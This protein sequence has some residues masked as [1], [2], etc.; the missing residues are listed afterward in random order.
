MQ[1]FLPALVLLV[2]SSV[3]GGQDPT[4]APSS[5]SVDALW[6]VIIV[7]SLL[8]CCSLGGVVFA[9]CKLRSQA[10]KASYAS[11][12]QQKLQR[13]SSQSHSQS[14]TGSL[15]SPLRRFPSRDRDAEAEL[16]LERSRVA[17]LQKR[18]DTLER[19]RERAT[20]VIY[21]D[22]PAG[23][24]RKE[25]QLHHPNGTP[26]Q[27]IIPSEPQ[28]VLSSPTDPMPNSAVLEPPLPSPTAG[29]RQSLPSL[30]EPLLGSSTQEMLRG[31]SY[32][33]V[34]T[35][36]TIKTDY[37]ANGGSSPDGSPN[38]RSPSDKRKL[39]IVD[40]V[41]EA[42][43]QKVRTVIPS[44]DPESSEEGSVLGTSFAES[45]RSIS[46][47]PPRR[48]DTP[49][50][51]AWTPGNSHSHSHP[52]FTQGLGVRHPSEPVFEVD[53]ERDY[54]SRGLR[55]R[56]SCTELRRVVEE[57]KK[58]LKQQNAAVEK[59]KRQLQRRLAEMQ[60]MLSIQPTAKTMPNISVLE[61]GGAG[62]PLLEGVM[63]PYVSGGGG[64]GGGGGGREPSASQ[65]SLGGVLPLPPS[66]PL[67]L[68]SRSASHHVP[69]YGWNV[70]GVPTPLE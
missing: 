23:I 39:Q 45:F 3:C 1:L 2:Y 46:P 53:P 35:V 67:R 32:Y 51:S 27:R 28:I 68:P 48:A 47:R 16:L 18:I 49:N 37:S 44:A 12:Q 41:E 66:P 57:E 36:E 19:T 50:S 42:R 62:N 65:Y 11:V 58:V 25:S 8:G 61:Q 31:P 14:P 24:L 4:A 21:R 69:V 26:T 6:V 38:S 5:D 55:L 54:S 13:A 59:E 15:G 64:G 9:V 52:S 43:R 70:H 63:M 60:G 22:H 56:E 40:F 30:C 17:D 7:V 10:D 34:Q 33:S 20:S 29:R